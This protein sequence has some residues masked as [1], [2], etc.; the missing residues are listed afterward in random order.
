MDNI[1]SK[2]YDAAQKASNPRVVSDMIQAGEFAA[3]VESD[4]GKIYVGV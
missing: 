2:L 3:A 1:W 4:S